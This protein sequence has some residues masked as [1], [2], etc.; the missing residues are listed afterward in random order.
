KQDGPR[1]AEGYEAIL[2]ERQALHVVVKLLELGVEP[3]RKHVVDALDGLADLAAAWRRTAAAC[4]VREGDG[5]AVIIGG[6][7][8]GGLAITRVAQ[9]GNTVRVNAG[10]RHQEIHA[11][12]EAPRPG[13]NRAAVGGVVEGWVTFGEPGIDALANVPT[14]RIDV[15]AVEGCQGVTAANDLGE[16]PVAGLPA[17]CSFGG[18]VLWAALA[19]LAHPTPRQRYSWIVG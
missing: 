7:Q 18:G 6:G 11:A 15:A 12:M 5:D 3:V 9:G 2:V 1:G 8:Q 14:I 10:L 19:K 13:G 16:R 4:L 17:A